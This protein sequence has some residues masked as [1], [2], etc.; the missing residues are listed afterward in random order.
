MELYTRTDKL[1]VR[2]A[3]FLQDYLGKKVTLQEPACKLAARTLV[4]DAAEGE[5][6]I[7]DYKA[8]KKLLKEK[9]RSLKGVRN[10]TMAAAYRT[11][12]MDLPTKT[13]TFA[14]KTD[15]EI[16]TMI[17]EESAALLLAYDNLIAAVK[18]AR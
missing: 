17:D 12:R 5:T 14:G 4:C 15:L 6:L 18:T 8:L 13:T 11:G 3:E 2:H 7:P 9:R 16:L 1:R 10:K